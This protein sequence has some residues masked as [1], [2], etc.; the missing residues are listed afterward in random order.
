MSEEGTE[1]RSGEVSAQSQN[2]DCREPNIVDAVILDFAVIIQM[3]P[4][5]STSMIHL[6]I[7]PKTAEICKHS[8]PCQGRCLK[9]L[10]TEAMSMKNL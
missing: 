1:G 6:H 2:K 3:L 8:S 4:S 10:S 9:K 5:T 7:M